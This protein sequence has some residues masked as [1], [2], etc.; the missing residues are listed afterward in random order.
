MND[1]CALRREYAGSEPFAHEFLWLFCWVPAKG[2]SSSQ[3]APYQVAPFDSCAISSL[4]IANWFPCIAIN[5]QTPP[6]HHYSG[7]CPRVQ[8][9]EPLAQVLIGVRLAA[10][11]FFS[12]MDKVIKTFPNNALDV[13]AITWLDPL[14]RKKNHRLII[15]VQGT[16]PCDIR[17][18]KPQSHDPCFIV[19]KINSAMLFPRSWHYNKI[20]LLSCAQSPA[21][22]ERRLGFRKVS[23]PFLGAD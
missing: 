19:D 22:G 4:V 16:F 1:H 20:D 18:K 23:L 21:A 2:N 6:S 8:I 7:Q 3:C 15:W 9:P 5:R 10:K 14:L 12:H 13:T 11:H 17:P